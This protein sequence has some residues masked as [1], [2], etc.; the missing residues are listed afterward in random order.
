MPLRPGDTVSMSLRPP[1]KLAEYTYLKTGATLTRVLGDDPEADLRDMKTLL[2]RLYAEAVGVD[3]DLFSAL[4]EIIESGSMDDLRA[5]I[6]EQASGLE[7]IRNQKEG[8]KAS[9]RRRVGSKA[10]S[11]KE[12]GVVR[13]KARRRA[14]KGSS[15]K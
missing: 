8:G 12:G 6:T 3:L 2:P 9:S 4:T 14:T 5:W 13:K 10:G 11:K 1:V 15:G 7:E